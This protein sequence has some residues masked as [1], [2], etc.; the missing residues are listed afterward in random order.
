MGGVLHFIIVRIRPPTYQMCPALPCGL[1]CTL[2]RNELMHTA[3]PELR[4]S[5]GTSLIN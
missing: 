1:P 2:R 3:D 5:L 4:L